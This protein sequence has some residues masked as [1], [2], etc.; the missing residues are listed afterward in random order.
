VTVT[1]DCFEYQGRPFQS[2]SAIARAITGNALEW[3][4]VL[5]LAKG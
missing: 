1:R 4:G 2:L 3:L 5:W